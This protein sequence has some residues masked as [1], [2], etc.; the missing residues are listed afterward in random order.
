MKC[1]NCEEAEFTWVLSARRLRA[2]LCCDCAYSAIL[3]GFR[4]H[5]LTFFKKNDLTSSAETV[6]NTIKGKAA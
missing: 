3:R 4:E 2:V 5:Q 1:S 6:I